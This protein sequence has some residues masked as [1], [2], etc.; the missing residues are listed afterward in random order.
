MNSITATQNEIVEE[1]EMMGDSFD[2]YSYLI[3]LS[4]IFEPMDASLKTDDRLVD[5]CQSHVWLDVRAKDDLFSFDA[6]SDTLIIKGVLFLLQRILCGQPPIEVANADID[7]LARTSIMESFENDRRRG[8]G[9]VIE[10][11]KDA[12]K[13]M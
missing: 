1:F 12:A 10:T 9:Y 7:F 11:L 3:E 13:A 6:D 2:Q 5:G 4:C 8:I